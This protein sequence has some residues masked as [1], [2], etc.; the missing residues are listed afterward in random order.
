M[1]NTISSITRPLSE[2]SPSAVFESIRV[3]F[4][5]LGLLGRELSLEVDGARY[6]VS[7]DERAFMVYR[8]IENSGLRHHVPGWPVC[9]VNADTIFE[10]CCSP[11]L[12]SDHFACGLDI[13]KW[14]EHIHRHCRAL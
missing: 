12:G 13:G 1:R 14:L 8:V 2:R 5:D 6:R 4:S 3:F 10:E 9:L 11:D 7:C